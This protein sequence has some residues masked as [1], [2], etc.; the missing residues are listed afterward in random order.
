M[1]VV[2]K[3]GIFIQAKMRGQNLIL[4]NIT[5]VKTENLERLNEI[6]SGNKILTLNEDI[7]N[8]FTEENNKE[9][10]FSNDFRVIATCNEGNETSLSE[11]FL[12]RFTLIYLD[13]YHLTKDDYNKT[14]FN[15]EDLVLNSYAENSQI[16]NKLN[17]ILNDYYAFSHDSMKLN[18]SQKINCL[19]IARK[20][21]KIF[22]EQ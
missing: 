5:N 4:K 21:S 22:E 8:T 18:L 1:I 12:S 7:Q 3:P 2:F 20:V 15:E 19:K 14:G 11:A 16:T 9:I 17:N 13:K 10:N 6:F